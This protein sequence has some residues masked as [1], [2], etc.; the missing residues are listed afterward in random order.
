[1]KSKNIWNAKEM[2]TG[3][4]AYMPSPNNWMVVNQ[5]GKECVICTTKTNAFNYA[6]ELMIKGYIE[7]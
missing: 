4:V 3:H 2:P 6:S 7:T 5:R 1:M